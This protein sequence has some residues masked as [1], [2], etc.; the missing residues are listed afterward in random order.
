MTYEELVDFLEHKISMSHVYQPLLVRALVDAGGVAT[1]RQLAQVFLVQ[2][3]SQLLYYE[4][5]IKEM[6]LKVLKR[7]EV[8]ASDGRVVSLN[9][10]NLTL[11]QKAHIRM[12]CEQKLQ[13]FVQKLGIGI[14]DYRLLDDDPIP[15]SL[16]FLVLKA[17][18]GRCQL[19][20]I[21]AK[22]RPIDVDHTV[23]RS[24]GGKAELTNLQA[25]CSKCNRSK[26]NQDQTDFRAWR[27]QSADSACVFFQP[28]AISKAIEKNASVFAILDKYPVTPGHLLIIPIRHASDFF[29]M[30]EGERRDA[31]QLLRLLQGRIKS[32]DAKV[33]GFNVGANCGETAGQTVGHA[34]IHLIPRRSGDVP[35]PR[36]GVRGVIPETRVY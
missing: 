36:G 31:D 22:E 3:E 19:C 32:E 26:R 14:W 24:R 17:A 30:T 16:R 15:D 8:I 35:D 7:H 34:H 18:G 28:P 33:T 11:V 23:P 13:S 27:L 29:S 1:V 2:D 21:L 6:P 25:L 9:A 12:I 4:K 5:R 10:N 20:G